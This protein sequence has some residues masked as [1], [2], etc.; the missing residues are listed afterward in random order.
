V[1]E[2]AYLEANCQTTDKIPPPVPEKKVEP[3]ITP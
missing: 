3:G 1:E 2:G